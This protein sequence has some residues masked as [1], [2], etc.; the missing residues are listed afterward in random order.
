MSVMHILIELVEFVICK[1]KHICFF[2]SFVVK[3]TV[4]LSELKDSS[5]RDSGQL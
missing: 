3:H 1:E 4:T 5:L 2:V